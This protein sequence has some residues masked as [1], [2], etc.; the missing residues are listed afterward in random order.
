VGEA[1]R[2]GDGVVV[3]FGE[4]VMPKLFSHRMVW[5]LAII[6]NMACFAMVEW[7]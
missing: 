5:V 2:A 6:A 1:R 7:S 4:I 3:I